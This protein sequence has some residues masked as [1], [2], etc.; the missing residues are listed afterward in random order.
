MIKKAKFGD[1]YFDDMGGFESVEKDRLTGQVSHR[2]SL[3]VPFGAYTLPPGYCP[4]YPY[5]QGFT[6]PADASDAAS[7]VEDE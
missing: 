6:R 3:V 5:F 7:V 4:K 1:L 2:I